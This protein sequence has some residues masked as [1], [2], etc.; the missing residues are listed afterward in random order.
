MKNARM[1]FYLQAGRET[2]MQFVVALLPLHVHSI[3]HDYQVKETTATYTM[4]IIVP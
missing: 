2:T 3:D 4:C 1:Q